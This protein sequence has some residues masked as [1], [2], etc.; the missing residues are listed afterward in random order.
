M[1]PRLL[2]ETSTPLSEMDRFSRQKLSKDICELRN[3]TK[4]PDTVDIYT[5]L[6]PA[7][8]NTFFSSSKEPLSEKDHIPDHKTHLLTNLK[9]QKSC[10]ACS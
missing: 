3:F 8:A 10:N 6:H 7:A 9:E 2:L 5:L 4:Q 1:N